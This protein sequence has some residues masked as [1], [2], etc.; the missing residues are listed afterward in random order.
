MQM[1]GTLSVEGYNELA[2][3]CIGTGQYTCAEDAYL[4]LFEKSKNPEALLRLAYLQGRQKKADEA[5]ETFQNY[6]AADGRDGNAMIAYAKLLEQKDQLKEALNYYMAS[7]PA[8]PEIVPVQATTGII[9]I[10][11]K[12]KRYREAYNHLLA[13]RRTSPI[14]REYLK[15]EM[16]SITRLL[17]AKPNRSLASH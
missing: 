17:R 6:F 12:Q 5:A 4:E 10:Y 1:T 8:R 3:M 11:K 13:F 9:R 2:Q 14:A 15:E 7:I 16:Q